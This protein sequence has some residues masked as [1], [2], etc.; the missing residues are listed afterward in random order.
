[1]MGSLATSLLLVLTAATAEPAAHESCPLHASHVASA[2]KEAQPSLHDE[3]DA[4]G[5]RVM[6]FSQQKTEH[7]FQLTGNGGVITVRVI[8]PSDVESRGQVREHLRALGPRFASGDF[9][10]PEAI[11]GRTPP[12]AGT[13]IALADE[14]SYRYEELERGGRLVINTAN[15]AARAAVHDF[16]RFQIEDHQT[17]DPLIPEG[18]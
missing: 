15:P 3:V 14:I 11:H 7:H 9:S 5:E 18:Q 16:L 12:G 10:Q 13:M 1:M 2:A 6:G 8:D 4:R 17:G